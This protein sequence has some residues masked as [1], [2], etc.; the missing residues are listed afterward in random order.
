MACEIFFNHEVL[1]RTDETYSRL[2]NASQTTVRKRP[3]PISVS[4]TENRF[5]ELAMLWL[6]LAPYQVRYTL[7]VLNK[8][9][10]PHPAT[11]TGL[12]RP[13]KD[14]ALRAVGVEPVEAESY[15]SLFSTILQG[16]QS[17]LGAL[18]KIW[19]QDPK[20]RASSSMELIFYF[21]FD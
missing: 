9:P 12:R 10:L 7:P 17:H 13:S 18:S 16:G 3:S 14:G 20:I 6:T 21:I 11:I 1:S 5:R 2:A 15:L 4:G 8:G 19:P